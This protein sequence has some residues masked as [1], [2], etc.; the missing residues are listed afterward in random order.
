MSIGATSE[1][2]VD[3]IVKR[4]TEAGGT[5]YTEP[6]HK[7]GWTYGCGFVDPDGHRWNVLYMDMNKMPQS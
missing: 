1:K 6:A 5:L 3:D 4:V 7:D 2:E